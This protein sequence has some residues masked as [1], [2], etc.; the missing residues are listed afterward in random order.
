MDKIKAH[1]LQEWP[2]TFR[3]QTEDVDGF[4]GLPHPYSVSA[5]NR[6][7]IFQEMYYWG[8]YFTNTGLI[9]N[10]FLAQAKNNVDNMLYM[11]GRFGFVPNANRTWMTSRSQPPFL[12]Q[13]V[14]D[15]YEK[16]GDKTWL[17]KAYDGLCREYDFWQKERMAESGLNRYY[18]AGFDIKELV[19][20]FCNRTKRPFPPEEEELS[21]AESGIAGWESGWD[22][23][24]RCDMYNQEC[25]WVDLNCLL[26][27]IEKNMAYFC[28]ELGCDATI[29]EERANRRAELIRKLMWND[30][31]GVFCDYDYVNKKQ[32]TLIS[33]AMYYPL[34]VGLATKEEAKKTV[35]AL[36]KLEYRYGVSACENRED[37]RELQWDYPYNWP[38]LQYLTVRALERYGYIEDA[39]RIA[40]KNLEL[41][42]LNFE[43]TG[44]LWEKYNV[45]TGE[46]THAVDYNTPP[47][48]GWSAATYLYFL[49]LVEE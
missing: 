49:H 21:Y 8:T 5:V 40:K 13:M 29:W 16:T 7:T 1:I 3:I 32:K 35:E 25:N 28:D 47:L 2:S 41:M 42:R 38:C 14:A 34:Y 20:E 18:G 22:F 36:K 6:N 27:G 9:N 23:S 12:S 10:G 30:E 33:Q 48:L 45:V 31:L 24:S 19:G 43:K 39:K 11:I 37:I 15:I 44:R 46:I 17:Q 4:I 26:F